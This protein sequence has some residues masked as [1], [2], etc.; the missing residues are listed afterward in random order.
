MVVAVLTSK[1]GKNFLNFG[2][3]FP[4]QTFTGY[5]PPGSEVA[6]DRWTVSLQGK[7]IGITGTSSSAR[8]RGDYD[9]VRNY[10]VNIVTFLLLRSLI[11]ADLG[12]PEGRSKD[13]LS[14]G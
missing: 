5:I 11:L 4:N 2:G 12:V 8:K 14:S 6:G 9:T 7:V 1:K 13:I 3:N 10:N